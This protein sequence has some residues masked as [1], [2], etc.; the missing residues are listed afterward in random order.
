[1]TNAN[2][3]VNPAEK[4]QEKV[5]PKPAEML[6]ELAKGAELC[7]SSER[8]GYAC[9]FV[10][11][12]RETYRIK[13]TSFKIWLASM[14]HAEF[15]KVPSQEAIK[16]AINTIDGLA[17]FEAPE[18]VL[19]RRVAGDTS[20]VVIDLG[21]ADWSTVVVTSDGWEVKPSPETTFVRSS[22]MEALPMPCRGGNAVELLAELVNV[23]PEQMPLLVAWMIGA[24]CPSGPYPV[25]GVHGEQGSAKST[26]CRIVKRLIDPNKADVRSAPRSEQDLFIAGQNSWIVSLE[27]LSS[28][29]TWLSDSLC[30]ISTGAG[31]AARTL[32]SDGEETIFQVQR[33]IMING[34]GELASRGDLLERSVLLDLPALKP[35]ARLTERELNRN[36][37]EQAGRI[38]GSLLDAVSSAIRHLGDVDETDLPR[39]ADFTLWALAGLRHFEMA[40]EFLEA[41]RANQQGATETAIEASMIGRPLLEFLKLGDFEGNA[42]NLLKALEKFKPDNVYALKYWPGSPRKLTS[43]LTRI[44]PNLRALGYSVELGLP[45][46]MIRIAKTTLHG[47]HGIK[48]TTGN[49]ETVEVSF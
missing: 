37:V 24:F 36:A 11:K 43:D 44:S 23:P 1:M 12:H 9:V 4:K 13:S 8:I 45:R 40:D 16:E 49:G 22:S 19:Y 35:G 42:S 3:N 26:L 41:Y 21:D 5:R 25:L 20:R 47:S 33:P 27:N 15:K 7:H 38:F 34:I 31:F 14:Y 2:D 29:S 32:Y 46:R 30:R 18:R 28:I 10:N 48:Q 39:M 17:I 6:V